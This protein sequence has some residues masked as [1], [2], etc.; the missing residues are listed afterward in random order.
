MEGFHALEPLGQGGVAHGVARIDIG[1]NP[2]GHLLHAGGLPDFQR[3]LIP[4]VAPA[5][6]EID[7]ACGGGDA[8]G[9]HGDI[10]ERIT[11]HRPQEL[12][13]RVLALAQ[14]GE[15]FAPI[16]FFQNVGDFAIGFFIRS[17]IFARC[18]VDHHDALAFFFEDAGFRFRAERAVG[19]QRLQPSGNAEKRV[20]RIFGQVV[21][22]G[23]GHMGEGIQAHHVGG[24]VGGGFGA[25]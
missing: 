14:G 3:A 1:L 8:L 12:R 5:D 15:L 20:P 10:V 21:F 4:A 24:A 19:N 22:H 18:R 25:A 6:G 13:L 2:L 7:V 23:F 16:F 9:M 11:Q 17:H